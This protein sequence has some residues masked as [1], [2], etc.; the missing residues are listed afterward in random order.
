MEIKDVKTATSGS[1]MLAEAEGVYPPG[2]AV[3]FLFAIAQVEDILGTLT[4]SEI[5]FS[6]PCISGVADWRGL[7][8]P[9]L[10][11]ERLLGF[12]P[13]DSPLDGARGLVVKRAAS[14]EV[15]PHWQRVVVRVGKGCRLISRV[16]EAIPLDPGGCLPAGRESAVKGV[17]RWEG[18]LLVV[19]HMENILS[20]GLSRVLRDNP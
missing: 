3:S 6:S 5:P 16:P 2:E 12:V 13:D 19:P 15:P 10:S 20:G 1:L 4:F 17:Y 7:P 11:L 14:P 8:L 18:G 9:V